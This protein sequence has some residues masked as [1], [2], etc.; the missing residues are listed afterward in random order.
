MSG[1]TLNVLLLVLLPLGAE[2]LVPRGVQLRHA[3][4]WFSRN[5]PERYKAILCSILAQRVFD[6]REGAPSAESFN[7]VFHQL[8]LV[9]SL[10][11]VSPL[12]TRVRRIAFVSPLFYVGYRVILHYDMTIVCEVHTFSWQFGT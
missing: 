10:L 11:R 6:I 7:W 12:P 9:G 3:G 8:R 2:S 1:A 5:S 4:P